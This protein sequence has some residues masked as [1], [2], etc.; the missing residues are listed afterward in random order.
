MQQGWVRLIQDS[1]LNNV[2]ESGATGNA[3]NININASKLEVN[4][5][6][7]RTRTL[8]NGNAGNINIKAGEIL[9]DN[10]GY[11][12]PGND[13]TLD[14]K[15]TIDAS[16]YSNNKIAGTGRSGNVSL[17]A[18]N[19]S[20]SLIGRG[21][22]GENKN[23]VISTYNAFDDNAGILG[24]GAGNVSLI[25]KGSISLDNAYISASSFSPINGGGEISLQGDESVSLA[26][27]SSL[28]TTSFLRGILETSH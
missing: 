27:N 12:T 24:Q 4:G 10:P 22:Q 19:G 23:K 13:I 16:N 8:G 20:I 14:E 25:A 3:G 18:T 28:V 17:E 7:I 26:N 5:G 9:I 1:Q 15:A 11:A 6:Q 21:E 2:V